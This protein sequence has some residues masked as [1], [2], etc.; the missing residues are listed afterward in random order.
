M[1]IDTNAYAVLAQE[2]AGD[3]LVKVLQ[4]RNKVPRRKA[5]QSLEEKVLSILTEKGY[6]SKD[7]SF[8]IPETV[9]D[10]LEVEEEDE[11]VVVDGEVDEGD[12]HIKPNG[13]RSSPS[14]NANLILVLAVSFI[15]YVLLTLYFDFPLLAVF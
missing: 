9:A 3:E 13:R 2:I 8:G 14:V 5:L 15:M 6:V 7:Q 12:V 10:L 4:I 11:E 1:I